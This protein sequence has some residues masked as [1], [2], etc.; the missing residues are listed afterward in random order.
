ML[1]QHPK[2]LHPSYNLMSPL[3]RTTNNLRQ[4][5]ISHRTVN[6]KRL[7]N[8]PS[9]LGDKVVTPDDHLELT[10]LPHSLENIH[11]S[12]PLLTCL[13]RAKGSP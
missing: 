1:R 4:L 11:L 5:L 8:T 13:C 6:P 10:L 2:A 7:V 3:R 9:P 12:S